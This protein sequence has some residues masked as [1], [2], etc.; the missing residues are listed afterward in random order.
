MRNVIQI[1]GGI[2]SMALLFFTRPVW[3]DSIV[4]WCD[5]GA[6]YEDVQTLMERVRQLVPHFMVVRGDQPDVIREHGHPVDVVPVSH[7]RFGERIFGPQPIVFQSY[8]DCC[9]RA[10]FAP[11]ER[12][13][14]ACGAKVVYRGQRDDEKRR[15]RIEHGHVDEHGI[16]YLFP[17]HDWS[18]ERVFRYMDY[19]A[20]EFIPAYYAE[21]EKTSRDCWSCTAYRDDNR[22]RVERLPL[23]QRIHVEGV[24]RRWHAI[25]RAET[26]GA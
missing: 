15:A 17:L 4:M 6:S 2:D 25:V 12:A 5:P 8:L 23:S 7:T 10:R 24:L 19:K 11:L 1:S 13:V 16:K 22:E 18:R 3:R 9:T 14:L 21:G 26:Q 20:P